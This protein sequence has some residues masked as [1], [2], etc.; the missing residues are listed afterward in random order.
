M[1]YGCVCS[2]RTIAYLG[3]G[4]RLYSYPLDNQ[5]H[6][7]IE[8]MVNKRRLFLFCSKHNPASYFHAFLCIR[9]N[10]DLR[11]VN[12]RMHTGDIIQVAITPLGPA[13]FFSVF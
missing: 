11:Q 12:P 8:N 2:A 6:R 7:E 4:G 9:P 13:V 10:F 5:N 1:Q 3:M